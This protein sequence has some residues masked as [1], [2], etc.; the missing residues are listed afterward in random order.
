M[1]RT[2][3]LMSL[4][5]VLSLGISAC[6]QDQ[7]ASADGETWVAQE[8]AVLSLQDYAAAE[9]SQQIP[10][11][12]TL[13][14]GT[15][16]GSTRVEVK[17]DLLL[18]GEYEETVL[19]EGFTVARYADGTLTPVYNFDDGIAMTWQQ[20]FSP[21]GKKLAILWFAEAPAVAQ[22]QWKLR[23]VDLSSGAETDLDLPE[24]EDPVGIVCVKWLDQRTLQLASAGEDLT[25][26]ETAK[27]WTYTLS[28]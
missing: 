13:P 4:C 23:V 19:P 7:P 11:D 9:E 25:K 26:D 18:Y 1:K 17:G 12:W 22:E 10:A 15:V 2:V 20:F 8:D 14:E 5:L 28:R 24:R 16:G 21:D 27:V 6:Q 3:F